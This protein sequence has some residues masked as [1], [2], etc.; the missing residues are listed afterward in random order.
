MSAFTASVRAAAR[1]AAMQGG[2]FAAG[3]AQGAAGY[4]HIQTGPPRAANG[5]G[6]VAGT[7]ARDRYQTQQAAQRA[8]YSARTQHAA[9]AVSA[10]AAAMA[11]TQAVGNPHAA[12]NAAATAAS[13][14]AR[15]ATAASRAARS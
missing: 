6:V 13:R 7:T 12:A 3:A 11:R 10:P 4:G 15:A 9:R 14:A 1:I 5:L 8:A 2:Q